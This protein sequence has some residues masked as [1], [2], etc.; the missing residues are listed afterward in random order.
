[1]KTCFLAAL[2]AGLVMISTAYAEPFLVCDPMPDAEQTQVTLDG[3][4]QPWTDYQEADF[5]GT[6]YC[7]LMDLDS[8][9]TGGHTVTAKARNI[10]GETSDSDPLDFTKS[11]GGPPAGIGVKRMAWSE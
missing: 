2:L 6:T 3:T 8:I 1:M 5:D 10:W 11:A 7:V 4:P 9:S